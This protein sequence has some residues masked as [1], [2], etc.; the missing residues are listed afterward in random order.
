MRYSWR[1][2]L[3]LLPLLLVAAL[4][5]NRRGELYTTDTP[6]STDIVITAAGCTSTRFVLPAHREPRISL[7]NQANEPMVFTLPKMASSV[8]LDPDERV[9]LEL[10]PYMMGEFAFF[11]L[12]RS[13]H[14]ALG[15]TTG[16]EIF[17][18]GLDAATL[19]PHALTSGRFVIEPHNRLQQLL[20]A[21]PSPT[22]FPR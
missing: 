19:Q 3:V 10:P 12:T 8:L 11:C 7:L 6:A 9:N 20:S 14:V 1:F 15:G 22:D 5:W 18:C 4:Q 21:T 13:T 16:G 17:V 2:L